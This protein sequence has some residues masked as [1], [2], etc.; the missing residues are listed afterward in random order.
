MEITPYSTFLQKKQNKENKENKEQDKEL[1]E[2]SL[3]ACLECGCPAWVYASE[4][5]KKLVLMCPACEIH[6]EDE[7]GYE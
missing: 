4:D 6:G 3:L 5:N 7:E 2:M 1:P